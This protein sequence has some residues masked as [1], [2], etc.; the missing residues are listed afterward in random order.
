MLFQNLMKRGYKT[1]V[2]CVVCG[3]D[4]ALLRTKQRAEKINRYV[5]ESVV[6]VRGASASAW[7]TMPGSISSCCSSSR[8]NLQEWKRRA[9]RATA[10]AII[11]N[12]FMVDPPPYSVSKSLMS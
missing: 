5:P 4:I 6:L 1:S 7:K 3:T 11:M 8:S 9:D 12:H 2:E 10:D